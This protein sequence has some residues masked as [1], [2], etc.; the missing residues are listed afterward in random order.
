M[1]ERAQVERLLRLN[2]VEVTAPDE[3]IKSVLVSARWGEKDVE[4][5]LIILK[6]NTTNHET[7]VDTLHKLYQSDH[8]LKPEMITALLGIDIDASKSD[9]T[10]ERGS[11]KRVLTFVQGAEIVLMSSVL[12][13]LFVTFAMWYFQIGY[14]HL[15]NCGTA[16]HPHKACLK[17]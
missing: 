9:I 2:N 4:T 11:R 14:F 10:V 6:E 3:E 5:A 16:L 15:S 7:H 13:A 8:K 1:L 17:K 12:A